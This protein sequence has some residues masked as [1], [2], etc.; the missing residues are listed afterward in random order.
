[1]RYVPV[2]GT[3]E[4]VNIMNENKDKICDDLDRKKYIK[5]YIV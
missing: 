5:R 2:T 4:E 1:M 3:N